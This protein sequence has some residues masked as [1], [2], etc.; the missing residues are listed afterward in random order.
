[1]LF[2]CADKIGGKG[3][4]VR[5]REHFTQKVLLLIRNQLSSVKSLYCPVIEMNSYELWP[6]SWVFCGQNYCFLQLRHVDKLV[7]AYQE[8]AAPPRPH[9]VPPDRRIWPLYRCR[10]H[11]LPTAPL[12]RVSLPLEK[13]EG[14]IKVSEYFCSPSTE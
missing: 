9:S 6:N 11:C 13:K 14:K 2:K 1:M 12:Q 3:V 5:I 4:F 7:S 8:P 10:L